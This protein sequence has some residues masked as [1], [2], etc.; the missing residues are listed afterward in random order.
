M[1]RQKKTIEL[2]RTSAANSRERDMPDDD[3]E[4]RR[5]LKTVQGELHEN[6]KLMEKVYADLQRER[7]E[8]PVWLEGL[9]RRVENLEGDVYG[10]GRDGLKTLVTRLEQMI[11][12][13]AQRRAEAATQRKEDGGE[14]ISVK[15]LVAIVGAIA[16]VFS[17]IVNG[18][19]MVI[20]Q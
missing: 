17:A 18:L 2:S 8:P 9:M 4:G 1:R 3:S 11:Q 10:N 13:A 14:E 19:F 15:L 6:R 5:L 16:V 12:N 7:R 20:A